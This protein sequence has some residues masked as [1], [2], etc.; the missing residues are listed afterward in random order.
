[1]KVGRNDPCPC[2]SGKKFK[3]CCI[4][5]PPEAPSPPPLTAEQERRKLRAER[6]VEHEAYALDVYKRLVSKLRRK[7]TKKEWDWALRA[8]YKELN[9]KTEELLQDAEGGEMYA[10]AFKQTGFLVLDPETRKH[11]PALAAKWDAAIAV[12]KKANQFVRGPANQTS[13]AVDL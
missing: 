12:W 13:V 3:H 8:E 7:P 4:D 9:S 2:G 5:K 1:M 11:N 6:E 10:Y